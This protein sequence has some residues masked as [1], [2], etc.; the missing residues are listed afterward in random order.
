MYKF[1]CN[2]ASHTVLIAMEMLK[3]W[4]CQQNVNTG[5]SCGKKKEHNAPTLYTSTPHTLT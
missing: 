4:V 1:V 5:T 3:P 2:I